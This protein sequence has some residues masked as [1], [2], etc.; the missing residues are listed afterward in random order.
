MPEQFLI[1]AEETVTARL[2]VEG[3]VATLWLDRPPLNALDS[4]LQ[5]QLHALAGEAGRRDDIAAVVLYGGERTFAAGADVKEM[6]QLDYADMV[7]WSVDL[8]AAFTAVARIPKP[9]VAAV[10]GYALGAGCELALCADH[11]IVAD[12]AMLGQPEVL[13]GVIPGAGG[14]QRLPRLIGPARAKV[15]IFTG[16]RVDAV[17]A[18]RI[19]LVTGSCQPL[20]STTP[21]WR[22]RRSSAG[23]RWR[24]G[25][26]SRRSTAGGD[27][28]RHRT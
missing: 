22:T 24:T 19:G 13:L 16:R 11:R 8:E 18:L 2:C 20:R 25:P 14:A 28:S 6:A 9:V 17:E 4:S 15:L 10:T 21:R 7:A 1:S 23:R 27:R 26:R 3:G 12:D 5:R